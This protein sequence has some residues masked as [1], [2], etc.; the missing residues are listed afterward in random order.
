MFNYLERNSRMNALMLCQ[1]IKMHQEMFSLM[2]S[3]SMYM[4]TENLTLTAQP[5]NLKFF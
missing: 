1:L 3:F 4:R 2:Y 5:T